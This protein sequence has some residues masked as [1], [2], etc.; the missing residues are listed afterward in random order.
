MMPLP[1]YKNHETMPQAIYK[2]LKF[3]QNPEEYFK[4]VKKNTN[5]DEVKI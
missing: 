5:L 4:T 2:F 3:V 1:K